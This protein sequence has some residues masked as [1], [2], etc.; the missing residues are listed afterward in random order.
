MGGALRSPAPSDSD[1]DII[2]SKREIYRAH[3]S[4]TCI[5]LVRQDRAEITVE[6]RTGAGWHSQVL[7]GNDDLVLPEF[8]LSCPVKE[9]Y[10]DTP[11]G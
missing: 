9:V 4:C 7:H 10:R 6:R 2:E 3:A 5:L 1:K 11:L 8:G